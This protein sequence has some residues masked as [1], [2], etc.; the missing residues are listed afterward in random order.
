MKEPPQDRLPFVDLEQPD[1]RPIHLLHRGNDGF[2]SFHRKSGDGF[3]NLFSMKANELQGYFPQLLPTLDEDA[4]FSVNAMF[5]ANKGSAVASKEYGIR[6]PQAHRDGESLRWLTS[7]FADIDCHKLGIDVAAAVAAVIRAQDAGKIPPAS[8][9]TR[10]GRGLWVWWILHDDKNPNSPVRAYDDRVRLWCN[11]QR[12]I[13]DL[14]AAVGADAGS[15]DSARITRV[16]GS[17]NSKAGVRVDYWL[18]AGKDGKPFAYTLPQL[19][20]AFNVQLPERNAAVMT[21]AKLLSE[22]G[23]KGQRGRWLVARK[24]FENLWERRGKFSEGTRNNA[25]FVYAT[26]LRSQLLDEGDVWEACHRLFEDLEQGREKYTLKDLAEAMKGGK[27]YGRR[28]RFGGIRNQTISDLLE[29]TPDESS[30]LRNWPP[31]KRFQTATT[32]TETPNL[33]MAEQRVR[34]QKV[35]QSI[36][37]KH[38]SVPPQRDLVAMLAAEGISTV[39][40]TVAKDLDALGIER[41]RPPKRKRRKS[42]HDKQRNLLD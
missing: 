17:V 42:A 23:R 35:L 13:T 34:R 4:Y 18:Q 3:E 22:K 5:R 36:L 31:A 28:G 8:M 7:C 33:S 11:V 24:N 1:Y 21:V 30:F 6:L 27:G 19:A 2:I 16:P 15:R 41:P 20:T 37:A 12:A 29:V 39:P 40:R 14:F 9:L 25:V 32:D 26:I 38:G 10:S